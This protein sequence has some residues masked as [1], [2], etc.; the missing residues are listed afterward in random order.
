MI[1]NFTLKIIDQ[2]GINVEMV[3]IWIGIWFFISLTYL[4]KIAISSINITILLPSLFS[5]FCASYSIYI[6][7]L[8]KKG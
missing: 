2:S 5:F 7:H 3:K 6:F 8:L 1:K 4:V